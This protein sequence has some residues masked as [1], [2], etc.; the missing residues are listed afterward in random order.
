MN[1]ISL[2]IIIDDTLRFLHYFFAPNQRN[3]PVI[4]NK[5]KLNAN[6]GKPCLKSSRWDISLEVLLNGVRYVTNAQLQ[7]KN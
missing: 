7:D 3:M 4:S 5:N 2:D 6:W 1:K